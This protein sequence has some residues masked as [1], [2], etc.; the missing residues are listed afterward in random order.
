MRTPKGNRRRAGVKP[1]EG[2]ATN[3]PVRNHRKV[4]GVKA[5]PHRLR[6]TVLREGSELRLIANTP[7]AEWRIHGSKGLR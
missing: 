4:I 1:G 2:S 7:L 6:L 5:L 3:P